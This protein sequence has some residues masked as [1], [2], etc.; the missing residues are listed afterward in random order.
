MKRPFWVLGIILGVIYQGFFWWKGIIQLP[1]LRIM[2][3]VTI[4][5][6]YIYYSELNS[7]R[8]MIENWRTIRGQGRVRFI[9]IE[10][11]FLRGGGVSLVLALAISFKVTISMLIIGSILPVFGVFVWAGNEIWKSNEH[12]FLIST[13]KTVGESM[14]AKQN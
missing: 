13:L 12:L 8:R 7:Q 1:D 4:A 14:S 5:V 11:V 2:I 3:I 6:C 10:Y 9:L